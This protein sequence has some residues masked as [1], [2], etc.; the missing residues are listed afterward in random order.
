MKTAPR[1]SNSWLG[2]IEAFAS[3]LFGK[4]PKTSVDDIKRADFKTST[5]RMGVR[6]T[7]RIRN[8]FRNRW[9]KKS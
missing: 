4:S 7:D 8:V 3:T 6:F 1:K 9:L 2:L 5:Q